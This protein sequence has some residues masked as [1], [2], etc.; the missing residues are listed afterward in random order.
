LKH[1]SVKTNNFTVISYG[2]PYLLKEFPS[3]PSYIC[4][5]GDGE[6]SIDAS[7]LAVTGSIKFKGKLPVTINE[8]YKFG[9]GIER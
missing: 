7:L 1:L 4:A 9:M 3:V 8:D 2:N 5:Y 6:V